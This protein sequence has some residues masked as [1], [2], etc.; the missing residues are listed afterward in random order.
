ME[1]LPQVG[2]LLVESMAVAGLSLKVV[3]VEGRYVQEAEEV[4]RCW[5]EGLS[6]LW[7]FLAHRQPA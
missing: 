4:G 5:R 2:Y 6:I 1:G 3:F 7:T